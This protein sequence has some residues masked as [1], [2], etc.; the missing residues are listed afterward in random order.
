M[1]RTLN[2]YLA[3]SGSSSEELQRM[4]LE[5]KQDLEDAS[6]TPTTT[7]FQICRWWCGFSSVR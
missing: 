2:D 6:G 5:G 1:C 3:E 7:E 4:A